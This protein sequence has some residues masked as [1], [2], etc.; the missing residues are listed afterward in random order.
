MEINNRGKQVTL[1]KKNLN[2]L[3]SRFKTVRRP[4]VAV[5]EEQKEGFIKLSGNSFD[6]IL[7]EEAEERQLTEEERKAL[8]E[9]EENDKELERIA[10]DIAKGL[11]ELAEKGKKIGKAIDEQHEML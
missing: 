2:L 1:L 6:L 10:E 7:L 4:S 3:V 5:G 8:K 11:D 9:F